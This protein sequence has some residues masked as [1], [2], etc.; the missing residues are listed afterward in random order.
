[1]Q[2]SFRLTGRKDGRIDV[3][4]LVLLSLQFP[5]V[6]FAYVGQ[7]VL[8]AYV[9]FAGCAIPSFPSPCDRPYRLRVLWN[10]L[11]PLTP[12]DALL[13][14]DTSYPCKSRGE[15]RVSQ[16]PDTSLTTCH[17]PWTPAAPQDLTKPILSVQASGTLKPSPTA[18]L[19]LT[20]LIAL[21]RYVSP[22][23]CSVPCVRF[24]CFVHRSYRLRH[25]R[26]T[27]YGLLVRLCP[28]G[29]SCPGTWAGHPIRST[30][31]RL[32]H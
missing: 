13:A 7:P 25:R 23:A 30:K 31:L 18:S 17:A 6:R 4:D 9:S 24:T 27:R 20:G 28:M 12:S 29:T 5:A 8:S 11:T 14:V 32:A 16:V 15:S 26:N 1:M 10:D 21:G 3:L 22:A 2:G 19:L